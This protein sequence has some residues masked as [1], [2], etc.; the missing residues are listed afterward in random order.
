MTGSCYL[1]S[2]ASLIVGVI[3]SDNRLAFVDFYRKTEV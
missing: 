1:P 2:L 3:K